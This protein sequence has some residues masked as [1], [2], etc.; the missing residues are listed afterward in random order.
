MF[1]NRIKNLGSRLKGFF[2][3]EPFRASNLHG[4]SGGV[5]ASS[6]VAGVRPDAGIIRQYFWTALLLVMLAPVQGFA[7]SNGDKIINLAT[8]HS[9]GAT[10]TSSSV[11]VTLL[12]CSQ[13]KIEFMKY[14]PGID[15]ATSFKV[16]KT[17]YKNSTGSFTEVPAP[18]AVGAESAIDLTAPIPLLASTMFHSGEPLLIRVT[19]PDQN[20]AKTVAETITIT[21]YDRKTGDYETLQLTETGPDTGLFIGYI[22]TKSG[23]ASVS[24][25]VMTVVEE[26]SINADYLDSCN[27]ASI[28]ADAALVDPYGIVFETVTGKPVDGADVE[29]ID[30]VTGLGATIYGDNGKSSN[31]FPSKIVSGSTATDSEGNLYSFPQGSYRYPFVKPGKYILK[32]TPPKTFSAP[33]TVPTDKIQ[34]LPGAPFTI[35]EPGSR[36]ETFIVPVGPAIRVDLPV[37]PAAGSV[38]L[39]KSAGKSI[40]SAGEF[41]SYEISLDN[42]DA[43][44]TVLATT[45]I[46]RLPPGFRYQKGS[47]LINS[48]AAADPI[49][50][51]DGSTM[52]FKAGAIA[53]KSTVTIRYVVAVGAGAKPGAAVNTATAATTPVMKVNMATATVQVQEP[54]MMSRSIIM[55]R[56]IVGDCN[57]NI[58][59][60]KK[61]LEGI[62]IYLEDGTFVF[63]DKFGKFHFE[64]VRPGSHVVQLDLDSIPEGY[65]IQQC[66]Q[67]SRFAGRAYSQFVDMQGGT[68]WRTDFYLGKTEPQAVEK[69]KEAAPVPAAVEKKPEPL[70]TAPFNGE[71][72]FE[73]ISSQHDEIIDY[74]F[75]LQAARV[76]LQNLRLAIQLPAG[77]TY[78]TGSSSL[79]GQ[80]LPDPQTAGAT[81]LFPLGNTGE[82]WQGELQFRVKIDKQ[83]S[84]GELET[85]GLL[86]FDTDLAG[87]I[88]TPEVTN[89]LTL[90]KDV[91]VVPL[92]LFVFRPHFPTFGDE[93][94]ES[95]KREL[96]ALAAE[97]AGKIV[98]RIDVTGHTDNV[99]IAPRSRGIH[100]DNAALSLTRAKSVGRYLAAALQ[101]PPA[102]LYLNGSGDKEPLATNKTAAGRALNRRVEVRITAARQLE[103]ATLKLLKERSGVERVATVGAPAVAKTALPASGQPQ[104][105][106]AAVPPTMKQAVPA[107]PASAPQEMPPAAAAKELLPAKS[108]I[109]ESSEERAELI[110]VINDGIVNYRLKLKNFKK[111]PARA[112]VLLTMP[113]SLLYMNSTSRLLDKAVVDP[114]ITGSTLKYSL[115]GLDG[116][117]KFDLRLQAL[118]DAEDKSEEN[119]SMATVEL[120]DENGTILQS[121]PASCG[122]S[123]DMEEII[124][125][126]IDPATAKKEDAPA[127]YRDDAE[128]Y[129]EKPV[130]LTGGADKVAAETDSGMHVMDEEG[131]HSP[132]DG[133][134]LATRINAVRIV[135]ASSLTPVLLLDGKE[136]PAD[137]I[138]YNAKD[139]L[140]GKSLL[141]Y[142][143]IDFGEAGEH[144]L[145]LKGL[146]SFGQ[147]RYDKSA[148]V[149]RTGE[150]T[151][152]RFVSAEGNIADGKTPVKIRV[153]LFDKDEKLVMANGELSLKGDL[154]PLI[155]SAYTSR[156]ISS[157]TVAI[158]SDG[159]IEFQPVTASGLYRVQLA[160]NKANIEVETYVKPKMRDWILVGIA[161]GTAGYNTLSG[162]MDNLKSAG[163]DEHLY[164]KDRLALFAKGTIKG[165]W[166][167]TMAYDSAKKST[168]VS[169]NALFQTIDPNSYYTLYGDAT[170]QGYEA[171]TRRRLY[172]KIERDQFY[173]LFGDFDTGL[174]ITEL[175]RYSRRMN[176]FKSEYR[177]KEYEVVTFGA[178]TGQSFV[179]DELRGDGTSGL[180]RLSRKGIVINSEKIT[181][182]TRDRFRSEIITNSKDMARFIDYNIDY[183]NGTI[184]FKSPLASKDELLNPV[185]IVVDYEIANAGKE[186]LTFGGR[187]GTSLL[188]GKLKAGASYIHEGHLSGE[189]NLY[190]LDTTIK[191]GQD[192]KAR[193]EFAT[194]NSDNGTVKNSGNAWLA[195]ISHS[196]KNLD[197]KAY[198]REQESGFGLGQQ[199]GSESGTRKFGAEG[200]YRFDQQFSVTGQAYRQ[201][202]LLTGAVRDYM[203]SQA[204]Y[205]EKEYSGRAGLRYAN[206]SLPAGGNATSIQGTFGGSWKTFNQRLTLRADH[207]QSLFSK[208]NNADFPTRTIFGADFQVTRQALLFAQEELTYGSTANTN[209][210]RVGVKTTPWSGGTVATSVVNDMRENS[211]RTFANVGLAQKWQLDQNWQVDGGLD[212][213]QTIRRSPGYQ[214]NTKVPPASG[215]DDFTAIS[216]GANYTER[217]LVWSNRIEY[218]NSDSDD[219]WGIISGVVNEQGLNWGWTTK[220]QLLHT[221]AAGGVSKTDADLRLGLA[222]RPPVT[223]WIILDRLDL[224]AADDKSAT[225]AYQGKRVSNNL[226]A[227]FKPDKQTQLAFQY[228]AKY[229]FEQIDAKDYSGFTDL[230]GVEGRYDLSKEWDLGLRSSLLHSWGINQFNYSVGPSIGYNVMENMWISLGYNIFGFHDKD[231]SAANYTAQGPFIQFRFKFDQNSVKDGLK[232]INQ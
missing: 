19:A 118:F 129:Q 133:N 145:Q 159:W 68:M 18:V 106:S 42:S 177:T 128:L 152:I 79:N 211:G 32:V 173:A 186:A 102:A 121:L 48:K 100:A 44:R 37:D 222:Y 207:E 161:E 55:G 61:G 203:D 104:E 81:L 202:N 214:L 136:I 6:P 28:S 21:V 65:R 125:P 73:M 58:D 232:A 62:G 197:G 154:R 160:Y 148:K 126:D 14:A 179:K 131:I 98:Q 175:S 74:R 77:A 110:A 33:S 39:R 199:K 41:L 171:A 31:I 66:E 22:Q 176:G 1:S 165:E 204:I 84:A 185:Y 190:G 213:N 5:V 94:D 221:Q 164:E 134:I 69:P 140:S 82:K 25:G 127:A 182:E 30:A 142:I 219:K 137:R 115:G 75:P 201:Y 227:N 109:K 112:T 63:S 71:I 45:V 108:I 191:L 166:L 151:H 124:R 17:Y 114:E 156:E 85:K 117:K 26:S 212:H 16:Q 24:N 67:N 43:F 184:F 231:F 215:G 119:N 103:T 3:L 141:T 36:A 116:S 217:K 188:D 130:K 59:E 147:V 10:E 192:T 60:N 99:R 153:Q 105:E 155:N 167:L 138:G 149:T 132:A 86:H 162:H 193:A 187:A 76:P 135:L 216:L 168:G 220:L 49:L 196:D 143:G 139:R 198:Y 194:T 189:N 83:R 113:K 209:T 111:L 89:L 150:I 146:D 87:D 56:V 27:G 2:A 72:T 35:L 218:R 123:D 210:T 158:D 195:E 23:S 40:V 229:V 208:N 96:D 178:E 13:S 107:A 226:N 97:L 224:I 95:D 50:S 78:L 54:F 174:S 15:G 169:D 163:S 34:T 70:P 7:A 206:D 57:E 51:A 20:I 52:T 183:D 88:T 200:A 47:T 157:A 228:G 11:V 225:A 12:T 29:L 64:G 8:F 230:I 38:W 223:R 4:K 91:Q 92:P 122:Y 90:S 80:P 120:A 180:Y 181:I 93:L 144:I 170:A 172:L 53:P 101:L 205:T 46:D 9:T